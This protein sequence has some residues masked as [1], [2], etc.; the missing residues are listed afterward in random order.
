VVLI[1]ILLSSFVLLFGERIFT[2]GAGRHLV[3]Q[4][5]QNTAEGYRIEADFHLVGTSGV[6]VTD[7]RPGGKVEIAGQRY[8]AMSETGFI[9]KGSAVKVISLSSS[10]LIVEL[11][12]SL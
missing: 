8:D 2:T 6:A 12:A 7:L 1:V 4:T 11:T 3:L 5:S 9:S 10:T